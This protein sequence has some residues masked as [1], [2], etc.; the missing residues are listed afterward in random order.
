MK[1]EIDQLPCITV[2]VYFSYS[3]SVVGKRVTRKPPKKALILNV[4]GGG[5]A[6]P[7]Y[8]GGIGVSAP[9]LY[10]QV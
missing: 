6:F 8:Y 7:I 5:Q 3:E 10:T 2:A 9:S 1:I 4:C